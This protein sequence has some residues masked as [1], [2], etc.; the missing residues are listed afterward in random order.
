MSSSPSIARKPDR[1]LADAPEDG[2]PSHGSTITLLG[3]ID[4][5]DPKPTATGSEPVRAGE[6]TRGSRHRS[7][8]TTRVERPENE[9]ESFEAQNGR[10]PR[11]S[12]IFA[13]DRRPFEHQLQRDYRDSPREQY[14]GQSHDAEQEPERTGR[15]AGY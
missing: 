2:R 9:R 6:G 15:G 12:S 8:R 5:P 3:S 11:F 7:A 10:H 14:F 1:R 13:G 4:V